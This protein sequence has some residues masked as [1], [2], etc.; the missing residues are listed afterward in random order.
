MKPFKTHHQ[1]IQVLRERG[2]IIKDDAKAIHV[3]EHENYYNMI[4]G[5]KH[6][7]LTKGLVPETYQKGTTFEELYALYSFDR[8]LR[9]LLIGYFLKFET[10]LKSKVAYRFS[11]TFPE[12]QAYLDIKNYAKESPQSKMMLDLVATL[13]NVIKNT[14]KKRN[15]AVSYYLNQYGEVPLWVLTKY[16]TFGNIQ[17]FY[18]CLKLTEKNKIAKDFSLDFKREYSVNHGAISNEML[19]EIIKTI[20][21]FRNV[22]AHEERLYSFKIYKPSKNAAIA[23]LLEINNHQLEQGNLFAVLAFLK[24][25]IPKGD[26]KK[27]LISLS[28]LFEEYRPMI[29]PLHFT[30]ILEIMGFDSNWETTLWY[31]LK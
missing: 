9:N 30:E 15:T 24:L 18:T 4:N 3:L 29:S 19:E 20:N 12:T 5:Y 11:E 14:G 8:D 22:C 23:K 25:V 16:L 31:R 17:Y 21:Y 7:F 27:L 26:Y 10:N 2:M 28:K 13:F 6:T 1:Q